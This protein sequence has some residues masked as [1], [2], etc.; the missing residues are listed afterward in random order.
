DVEIRA[1]LLERK[2]GAHHYLGQFHATVQVLGQ[3]R[4]L[5]VGVSDPDLVLPM[6]HNLAVA[7]YAQG[8]YREAVREVR[9]ALAQVR[10]AESPRAA[11]YVSNLGFLLA[12]LGELAE[13]RAAAEEGLVAAQRFSNRAQECI[14]QQTLAQVLVQS[15]DFEGALA[16]VKRAE[17]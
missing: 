10:G 14:N 7:Y 11:L 9:L 1:R 3:V 8:R 5:L 13:A 15:G 17:E 2:A 6:I 4:E 12:E 16:A